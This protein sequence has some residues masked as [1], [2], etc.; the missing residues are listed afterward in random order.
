MTDLRSVFRRFR[1]K[2][3]LFVLPVLFLAFMVAP[4][5]SE[6]SEHA[7]KYTEAKPSFRMDMRGTE[8]IAPP[9]NLRLLTGEP[10]GTYELQAKR[11]GHSSVDDEQPSL[12]GMSTLNISGS[13]QYSVGQFRYLA[14]KITEVA[15][16]I[17][18]VYIVDL[19]QESHVFVNDDDEAEYR[20][21]AVSWHGEHN[22]GNFGLSTA[23]A[24]AAE[25]ELFE[26]K[27]GETI[28][29]GAHPRKNGDGHNKVIQVESF[30]TEAELVEQIN[31]EFPDVE[32]RYLRL[33][34][35]DRT[36]PDA[37]IIDMF[38]DYVKNIDMDNSWLHFHCL[39]G[40]GRTGI[41]MSIYD[42]M[43]N[44]GVPMLDILARQS[45]TGGS[46]PLSE[47]H[48]EEYLA[49][50]DAERLRLVPLVYEYIQENRETNYAVPWSE[51]LEKHDAEEQQNP[52]A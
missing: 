4:V 22:W 37:E 16:E 12:E 51:W 34:I 25:K 50:Y 30:L 27:I 21:I 48:N 19:R 15:P 28:S 45:M 18:N 31:Q 42:M 3:V 11:F 7:F 17:R 20:G 26:S 41:M 6:S 40:L 47:G 44:P 35:P 33:A 29:L 1:R 23:E 38:I 46:Y 49:A 5:S 52:A 14:R 2:S 39:A 9:G 8:E 24:L 32:F 43:K 36:F 13:A 10:G